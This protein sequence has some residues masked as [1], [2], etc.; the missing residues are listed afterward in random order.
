M[1][2]KR[3]TLRG[4]T[5]VEVTVA[6]TI[7]TLALVGAFS[8][9]LSGMGS[10]A[11]G[12]RTISAQVEADNTVALVVDALREATFV[13]VSLD[14]KTVNFRKP[15]YDANGNFLMDVHG[16]PVWDGLDRTIY[17][18]S[19]SI[20]LAD[21]VA[22]PW[23]L[24]SNVILTDPEGTPANSPYKIFTP[25]LGANT[26]EV[27]VKIVVKQNMPGNDKLYGRKR[28]NVYLRN[29]PDSIR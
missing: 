13:S 6:A 29:I 7:S 27:T 14:G 16:S 17:Y 28:E 18:D 24:A 25:G 10:W 20:F 3:L 19:G 9:F 4:L 22:T 15:Q 21:G 12:S 2:K 5:V 23:K 26:R 1:R 8:V 11:T